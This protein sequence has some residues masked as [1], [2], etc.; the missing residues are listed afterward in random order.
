[1]AFSTTGLNC[2][3]A[4]KAGNAPSLYMYSTTDALSVVRATGYFDNGTTTN[5]GMRNTFKVNDVIIVVSSTGGTPVVSMNYVNANSS[6]I[7]DITDGTTVSATD[8]D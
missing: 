2:V 4:S 3:S 1:M 5:T 6:G 7:I 8:T